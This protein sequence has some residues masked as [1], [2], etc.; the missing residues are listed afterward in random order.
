MKERLANQ[1]LEP[2]R[3]NAFVK[4]L[5]TLF[6]MLLIPNITWAQNYELYLGDVQVTYT[7]KDDLAKAFK[8]LYG[9]SF[10]TGTITF[11]PHEGQTP[12]TLTFEN[13]NLELLSPGGEDLSIVCGLPDLIIHFKGNNTIKTNAISTFTTGNGAPLTIECETDG[14]GASSLVI[15]S[16]QDVFDGFSSLTLATGTYLQSE[17]PTCY[18]NTEKKFLNFQDPNNGVSSVSFTSVVFYPLW[19][20]A[21]VTQV[22]ADNINN[23]LNDY[24]VSFTPATA[25]THNILTLNGATIDGNIISGL[26]DLTIKLNGSNNMGT[27]SFISTNSSA[28]LSFTPDNKNSFLS[29]SNASSTA[30]PWSGFSNNPTFNDKLVY[31]PSAGYQIIKVMP[32]PGISYDENSGNLIFS[33]LSENG[34]QNQFDCYYSVKYEEGYGTDVEE[35][36]CTINVDPNLFGLF[37]D[38][39]PMNAAPCTVTAYSMYTDPFN[40]IIQSDNT[41]AKYYI[42]KDKTIVYND[43]LL[44]TELTTSSLELLPSSLTF[45]ISSS[46]NNNVIKLDAEGG[47]PYIKGMGTATIG[48]TLT[49]SG[50]TLIL[51]G[52]DIHGN[53]IVH[54]TVSIV[55]PAPT[56]V[57]DNTKDYL[58]TDYITIT[59]TAIT[60]AQTKILY[61]W[62]EGKTTWSEYSEATGVLART[63]IL[64]AKVLLETEKGDVE[65]AEATPVAFTTK[66]DISGYTVVGIPE[67]VTY[68]GLAIVLPDFNVLDEKY[69][70]IAST[71]YT[72]SYQKVGTTITPVESMKEV[73]NYQIVITGT[74]NY[75]SEIV[76][77]FAIV[78]ADFANVEI[79]T[80]ADQLFTGNEIKPVLTV[81]FKNENN[82]IINVEDDEYSV[83]YKDNTN[84]G[85]ATVTLTSKGKSFT[86]TN[87][88]TATFTINPPAPTISPNPDEGPFNIGQLVTI[89]AY[90]APENATI[91]YILGNDLNIAA[92]TYTAP[93]PINENTIVNAWV[94]VT[95]KGTTYYSKTVTK[96]YTVKQDPKLKFHYIW[97]RLEM[98]ET[99]SQEVQ[100]EVMTTT[101]TVTWSSSNEA[102][103]KVDATTG[104]V[105]PVAPSSTD[106]EITATFAGDDTYSSAIVSYDVSVQK[107]DDY[108]YVKDGEAYLAKV[109]VTKGSSLNIKGTYQVICPEEIAG[110]LTW[111]PDDKTIVSAEDG[112]ISAVGCGYTRIVVAFAG[113]SNYEAD[114]YEFY[115]DAAPLAPTIGLTAGNYLSTH[116]PIT[117][118]KDNNANTTISYTWDDP[119][120]GTWQDYTD[121]G[122]PFQAGTLYARV[123]YD[124]DYHTIYSDLTSATYT[125]TQDIAGCTVSGNGSVTYTGTDQTPTITVTPAGGGTALTIGTDYTV[126]Y[127]K[128]ETTVSTPLIDAA[129]YTIVITAK[130]GSAYGGSKEVDF[131]IAKADLAN[132]EIGA[133]ASQTYTG[134]Q[135]KPTPIIVTFNGDVVS[136]NEYTI[137][138]GEN[139]NAGEGTVTLTSKNKN[140]STTNTKQETFTIEQFDITSATLLLNQ[141]ELEF[142]PGEFGQGVEQSVTITMIKSGDMEISGNDITDFFTI[143]GNI[144]SSVGDHTV[145]V[146]AKT[147][148]ANNFKG[149]ATTTFTI[150]NRTKSATDFNFQGNSYVTFYDANEDW[151]LPADLS[152][153][154]VTGVGET[155]VTTTQVSYIKKGVPVLV[156]NAAGANIN[157]T[158]ETTGFNGNKL[159]YAA[160][161]VS[162]TGKEYILYKDAFVKA[163]LNTNIPQGKCYLD[164][165]TNAARASFGI[166][167]GDNE[168][169]GIEDVM[170]DESGTEKWYDLQG[171]R[172]EKPTKK[173]LYIR[174]GKTVIIN[175][176]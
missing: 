161:V 14:T 158:D 13:V 74:G 83:E 63:G 93:F 37:S 173:G 65:S 124:Y 26:D 106:V 44:D 2:R 159:K 121:A 168:N 175:N 126:S 19:I 59:Q 149:S 118:T 151:L 134:S 166:S 20:G 18:D 85:T 9:P 6:A 152:A 12:N 24:S 107:G 76:K 29:F 176:K 101:P 123:V 95:N 52:S 171:R 100:S 51:N 70:P 137:S 22:D 132:V 48:A 102:V 120:N 128:G 61:T 89:T 160:D 145:T 148:I 53:K 150:V 11:T 43:A 42:I 39:I 27:H 125:V 67:S 172:I 58:N 94:E 82:I 167:H 110:S 147:D 157:D 153:Y 155:E 17:T 115:V 71:D 50:S 114:T 8:E 116:D 162:A 122:V 33:D 47:K 10:V 64:R 97:T 111:T 143:N 87:T 69:T 4:I 174:N 16:Y 32:A 66:I 170:F 79:T 38:P 96:N 41:V 127:K 56:I 84:V 77:S 112:V 108:L 40:N 164:L 31:L 156:K 136:E 55:P 68:T 78:E 45:T 139:I 49:A 88:K 163:T 99:F 1:Q 62:G 23:V 3:P 5:L 90:Q 119:E 34:G 138:Y 141:T 146:T 133:I 28:S 98:G 72:V 130:N 144:A 135:I 113:N 165:G 169:T 46:S 105:T 104:V 86:T 142:M 75:G 92:T 140:F 73:G 117:I 21:G 30:I 91:K 25:T 129:T 103:A 57:K 80:I 109:R 54:G 60:G 81:K 7:N 35:T 36:I 154:I 15:E 131:T